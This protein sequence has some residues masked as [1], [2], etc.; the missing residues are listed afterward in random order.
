MDL[1]YCPQPAAQLGQGCHAVTR[2][3]DCGVCIKI[4]SIW[5]VS[6]SVLASL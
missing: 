2:A 5:Q 6:A 4:I 1:A 3:R